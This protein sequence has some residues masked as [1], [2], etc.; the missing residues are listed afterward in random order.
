MT[1]ISSDSGTLDSHRS[2]GA[3]ERRDSK[4][5][6]S[7]KKR[8]QKDVICRNLYNSTEFRSPT[9]KSMKK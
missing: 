1:E 7:K 9:I 6:K 5:V 4:N 2:L 8:H 3:W